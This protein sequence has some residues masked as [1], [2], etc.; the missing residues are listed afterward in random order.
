MITTVLFHKKIY[1][2]ITKKLKTQKILQLVN[3]KRS[4][5]PYKSHTK[6]II[7]IWDI[8]QNRPPSVSMIISLQGRPQI[9]P[10]RQRKSPSTNS[11]SNLSTSDST[12]HPLKKKSK[13]SALPFDPNKPKPLLNRTIQNAALFWEDKKVRH[14]QTSQGSFIAALSKK[15]DRWGRGIV[16]SL[17]GPKRS[18]LRFGRWSRFDDDWGGVTLYCWGWLASSL[19]SPL[20]S[21]V[22][23]Y[24]VSDRDFIK[25]KRYHMRSGR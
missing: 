25:R 14:V 13:I 16:G 3:L 17:M 1:T 21:K 6:N 7:S 15:G 9:H 19:A 4:H 22:F 8:I 11:Y 10:K 18:V 12:Q 23:A 2:N 24:G 20:G 5:K